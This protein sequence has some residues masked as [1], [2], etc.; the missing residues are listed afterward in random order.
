MPTKLQAARQAG[1]M[2][3][4]IRTDKKKKLRAR[5]EDTPC[6]SY[7]AG[8]KHDTATEARDHRQQKINKLTLEENQLP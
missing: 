1:K 5:L 3:T 6:R 2:R 7:A 8:N 4:R